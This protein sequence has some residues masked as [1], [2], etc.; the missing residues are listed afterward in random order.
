VLLKKLLFLIL[1]LSAMSVLG[2]DMAKYPLRVQLLK[3]QLKYDISATQ[4]GVGTFR[5]TT[6]PTQSEVRTEGTAVVFADQGSADKAIASKVSGPEYEVV[7][8][9]EG[10][11][12]AGWYN[13]RWEKKN[14][15]L[16]LLAPQA[17]KPDKFSKVTCKA[18]PHK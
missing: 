16:T 5:G 14:A 15:R 17:G 18:S 12:V 2:E 7:C 6:M 1:L 11:L 13:A 9:A 4:P 8:E 10:G 3:D